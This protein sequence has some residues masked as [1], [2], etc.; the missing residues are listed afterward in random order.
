MLYNYFNFQKSPIYII[1]TEYFPLGLEWSH[2]QED[3]FMTWAADGKIRSYN[4]PKCIKI[5]TI[6]LDDDIFCVA[7]KVK[8]YV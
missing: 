4:Y 3:V 1:V 6:D 5:K 8:G 2:L 7:F